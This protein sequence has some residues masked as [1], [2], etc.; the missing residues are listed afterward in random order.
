MDSLRGVSS[1]S[2]IIIAGDFNDDADSPVLKL[3]EQHGVANL[4]RHATGQNGARGTYRYQGEW[5]SLDHVF[6]SPAIQRR[7]QSAFIHSPRF[8]LEKDK[9]H[10]GWQP[11]RT[12]NGM[13]YRPGYSDHLPLVVKLKQE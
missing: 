2:N 12:Y 8:I 3:L 6:G 10:G 4:T 11:L 7:L 1:G 13:K 9:Q 5:G